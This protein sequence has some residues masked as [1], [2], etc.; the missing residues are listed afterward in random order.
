MPAP[1]EW[2]LILGN[3]PDEQARV[4]AGLLRGER[5]VGDITALTG[6]KSFGPW[7]NA[8]SSRAQDDM[9]RLA[10]AAKARLADRQHQAQLAET[11][12]MHGAQMQRLDDQSQIGKMTAAETA[13]HNKEQEAIE[14]ERIKALEAI[15]AI[16][17]TGKTG[18]PLS[19]K[20]AFDLEDLNERLGNTR[21]YLSKFKDN[22]AGMGMLGDPK[23]WAAKKLGSW[24]P[25]D[26]QDTANWWADV[27]M[28]ITNIMRNK[29]FGSALSAHEK[30]AWE[31][32][33]KLT[34]A[35][36]PRVV[37]ATLQRATDLLEKRLARHA[38]FRIGEGHDP[39][40]LGVILSNVK[41]LGDALNAGAPVTGAPAVP[42]AG[43]TKD[44]D[45]YLN[46]TKPGK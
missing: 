1:N 20:E 35:S 43:P 32:A 7:G 15:A 25:Q 36:D 28:N 41:S 2:D 29:I 42:A 13:R 18:K 4:L 40:G 14:R 10:L 27:R 19:Q 9:G 16:K 17:A 23:M 6:G 24:A 39:E 37:R 44:A 31:A 11:A 26:A 45:Y 21:D 8:M 5:T 46:L 34:P 30:A 3:S 12:R 22:Y 38:L 33:D